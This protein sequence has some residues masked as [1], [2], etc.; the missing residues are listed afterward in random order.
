MASYQALLSV[1]SKDRVG[2]ISEVAGLL[3]DKGVNL[4]DTSFAILAKGGE[5][6]SV[7]DV[8]SDVSEEELE[9]GL[10]SLKDLQN[11]DIQVK[12][13]SVLDAETP[14]TEIT[15]RIKCEGED[16]PGLLARLC[17]VFIEYDANIVRLKSDHREQPRGAVFTTRFSVNIPQNRAANCLAAL[18][19]TAEGLGQSLS[20]ETV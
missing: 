10:R 9:T 7:I 14:P 16:Q 19:N 11:A 17:E 4:G 13:F 3:F 8:P 1:Y 18:A 6:S 20:S 15:H 2:L 12:R 5:F